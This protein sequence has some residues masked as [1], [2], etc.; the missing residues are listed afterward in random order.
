[1]GFSLLR[2][3]EGSVGKSQTS[4]AAVGCHATFGID[5]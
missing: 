3:N 2:F 1:M 4:L 5:G